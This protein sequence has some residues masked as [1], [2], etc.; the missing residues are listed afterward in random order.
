MIMNLFPFTKLYLLSSLPEE[1]IVKRLSPDKNKL[2]SWRF[3][4]KNGFYLVYDSRYV[5]TLYYFLNIRTESPRI[6]I[7]LGNKVKGGIVLKIH[8]KHSLWSIIL[9]LFILGLFC[10]A[11]IPELGT[12]FQYNFSLDR[13]FK[14]IKITLIFSAIIYIN[15]LIP[16]LVR[17]NENKKFI[18]SLLEAEPYTPPKQSTNNQKSDIIQ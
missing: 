6:W 5:Y 14:M 15:L 3:K 8:Q 11:L 10:T 9:S 13:I 7:Y 1:E 18:M 4:K 16:F 12:I 17:G 2:G